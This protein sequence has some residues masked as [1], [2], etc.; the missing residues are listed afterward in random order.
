[1]VLTCYCRVAI[2]ARSYFSL[3][4]GVGEGFPCC[5]CWQ[6]ICDSNDDDDGDSVDDSS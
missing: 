5:C 2:I 3:E 1:M 6:D 4:I